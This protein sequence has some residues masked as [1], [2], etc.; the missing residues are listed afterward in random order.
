MVEV[1]E[2]MM[3]AVD[4]MKLMEGLLSCGMCIHTLAS[5]LVMISAWR[6][7]SP[8]QCVTS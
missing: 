6:L 4:L 2:L 1:M 3:V 5:S 7:A 8:I